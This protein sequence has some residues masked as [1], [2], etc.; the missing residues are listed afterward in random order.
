MGL[1][2][3]G[4]P[5]LSDVLR[6]MLNQLKSVA[7]LSRAVSRAIWLI[8]SLADIRTDSSTPGLLQKPLFQTFVCCH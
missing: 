2:G 8:A 6:I 3:A 4:Q 5:S 7:L 1:V